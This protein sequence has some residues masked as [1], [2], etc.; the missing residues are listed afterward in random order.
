MNILVF[1]ITLLILVILHE[2]GHFLVAKKFAIKVLEFGFGIPPKIFG[3]KIGETIYSLNWLPFGGF[4]R[5]LGEDAD[6]IKDEKEKVSKETWKK[7]SFAAQN[8]WKRIAVVVA[9]VVMNLSLAWALFYVVL[10]SQGFSAQVPLFYPFKFVG[11]NQTQ[12]ELILVEDVAENSPA[13]KS[14]IKKNE[15]VLALNGKELKS[16]KDLVEETKLNAGKKITLT[17]SDPEKI[18]KRDVEVTPREAPPKG[19]GALGVR[20]GSFPVATLSYEE[21]L[22]KVL[23]GPIHSYNLASYSFNILGKLI[24]V[25]I[26]SNN[27]QPVSGAVSGP[28]GITSMVGDILS[29]KNPIIP[30]LNFLALLSL[31]LAIFNVLPIPG[32]DGGRLFFLSIEAVTRKRTHATL[33]RYAHT[34]G[35]AVLMALALLITFSDINKLL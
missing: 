30:Y 2:L 26:S 24:A 8:V 17:I 29:I 18:S 15:R 28:V 21:P 25:S 20:L 22:Q 16:S 14:G 12:E 23:S 34:I 5:L 13:A 3:K 27:I 9:G 10:A 32:L 11:V 4:V 7:R 19:E 33:E 6:E 31:N 35:F 1:I